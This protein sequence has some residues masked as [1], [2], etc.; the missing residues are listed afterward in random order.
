M[1][2]SMS[3]EEWVDLIRAITGWDFTERDYEMTGERAINLERIF[4]MR[5]GI[6]RADDTLPKRMQEEPLP[7]GPAKG[8]LVN[9][10]PLLDTYYEYRGWDKNTGKPTAEKLRE[11]GLED[12]IN[13]L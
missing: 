1:G 6:T 5:E 13:E 4:N 10:P 12:F 11:L 8:E 3:T 2:T 9:L 7:A